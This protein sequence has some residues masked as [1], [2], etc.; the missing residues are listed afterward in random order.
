M[1][2]TCWA[3]DR[4]VHVYDLNKAEDAVLVYLQDVDVPIPV[5][6]MTVENEDIS[7]FNVNFEI[8]ESG[9]R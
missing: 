1:L 5:S 4:T 6:I 2:I 3:K 8:K 7:L 9:K